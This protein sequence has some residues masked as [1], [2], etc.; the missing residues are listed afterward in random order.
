MVR[1]C[2]TLI[3]TLKLLQR[4]TVDCRTIDT[5]NLDKSES[6]HVGLLI[7]RTIAT[8]APTTDLVGE[9]GDVTLD[10]GEMANE[11]HVCEMG[12]NVDIQMMVVWLKMMISMAMIDGFHAPWL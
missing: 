12:K 1:Q 9:E 4:R 11:C 5:S 7:C 3:P 6:S 10:L 8:S 2:L